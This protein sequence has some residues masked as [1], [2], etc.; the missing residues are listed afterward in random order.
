MSIEN[1]REYLK[2]YDKEK[3]IMEFD[4]SSATVELAAEAVGVEPAKIT[5]TLALKTK[6]DGCMVICVSGDGKIDN[7]K[8][9]KEFGL[10]ARMLSPEETL[11]KTG[12]AI[13]GVCP[14]ALPSGVEA[15]MDISMKRFDKVYPAC[16]S[17]NS[18]IA[19]SCDKLF[20]I[21]NGI[22]WVDICKD[23]E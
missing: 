23:W 19:L 2:K 17:S 15:F 21:S 12:H 9:K 1:V 4:V 5:K 11:E 13:G 22:R 8:F 20:E 16:G 6:D 10:K 7:K 3:D 18:A 14:F